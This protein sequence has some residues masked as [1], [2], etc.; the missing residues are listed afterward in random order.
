MFNILSHQRNANQNNSENTSYT[1]QN[2]YEQNVKWQAHIEQGEYSSIAGEGTNLYSDFRNQFGG[3]S[4]N[5][6]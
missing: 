5:W 4:E 1:H 6:A 3:F 2:G